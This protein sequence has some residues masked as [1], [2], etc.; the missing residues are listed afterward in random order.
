[1]MRNFAIDMAFE[2]ISEDADPISLKN[3]KDLVEAAKSRLD[4]ILALEDLEAF[5]VFDEHKEEC[6]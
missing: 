6:K 1:M 4:R 2:F 5:G 3:L